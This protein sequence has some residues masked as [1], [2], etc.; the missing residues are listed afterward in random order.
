MHCSLSLFYTT[1]RKIKIVQPKEQPL[2]QD[3]QN[4][5]LRDTRQEK[6]LLNADQCL[7]KTF[8]C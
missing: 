2:A 3:A 5:T 4:P 7:A 1:Y 8:G 6:G